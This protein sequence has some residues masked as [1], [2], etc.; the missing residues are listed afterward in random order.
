MVAVSL[1]A[2]IFTFAFG[3]AVTRADSTQWVLFSP[4]NQHFSI[5]LPPNPVESDT[6]MGDNLLHTWVV[7]APDYI[8]A[9]SRAISGGAPYQPSEVDADLSSF[10]TATKATVLSQAKQTWPSPD[11]PVPSLRFSFRMPDGRLGE[12]VFVVDGTNG[13]GAAIIKGTVGPESAE[14]FQFVNSLTVLP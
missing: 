4:P 9:V 12:G 7:R 8:Y 1:L 2:A 10:L 11:G 3:T 14:M 6:T 5:Q 13:F